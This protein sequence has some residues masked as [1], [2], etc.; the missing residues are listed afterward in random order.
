MFNLTLSYTPYE[1]IFSYLKTIT[2]GRGTETNGRKDSGKSLS[3][4]PS[5]GFIKRL[6]K[7]FWIY[8][9]AGVKKFSNG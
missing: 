7:I 9:V 4:G 6:S 2:F 1:N 8:L 3:H 5:L